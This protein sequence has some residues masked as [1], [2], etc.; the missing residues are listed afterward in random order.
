MPS[1]SVLATRRIQEALESALKGCT[2]LVRLETVGSTAD[3][4]DLDLL[5]SLSKEADGDRIFCVAHDVTERKKLEQLRRDFV[6]MVSHDLRSPLTSIRCTLH[7]FEQGL[8]GDLSQPGADAVVRTDS[9]VARLIRL[10]NTLLDYEK[11]EAGHF[12]LTPGRIA[13]SEL[14]QLSLNSVTRLAEKTGVSLSREVQDCEL[15][16]DSD[17]IVQVIVNLLSNAIKFSEKGSSVEIRATC[18]QQLAQVDIIDHS[19]ASQTSLRKVLLIWHGSGKPSTATPLRFSLIWI[20][21]KQQGA[22]Q[23]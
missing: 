10:I 11:M 4:S 20:T 17:K 18:N 9:E 3:S 13:L 2:E 23:P 22:H 5:W 8:Y 1:S 15:E 21:A 16:A 14:I 12:H 7:L 6:A 19:S